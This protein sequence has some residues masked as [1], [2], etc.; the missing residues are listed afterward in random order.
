MMDGI[1]ISGWS[2]NCSL[3]ASMKFIVLIGLSFFGFQASA[4]LCAGV[5]SDDQGQIGHV[6]ESGSSKSDVR[7]ILG[8][9]RPIAEALK[10]LRAQ[11]NAPISSLSEFQKE[12]IL[13]LQEGAYTRQI[14]GALNRSGISFTVEYFE[15][16]DE[17]QPH[18]LG[19][20]QKVFVIQPTNE[21]PINRFARGLFAKHKIRLVYAPAI[22]MGHGFI[23][24]FSYTE[25]AYLLQADAIIEKNFADPLVTAHEIKHGLFL[26]ERLGEYSPKVK[27]PVQAYLKNT[28]RPSKTRSEY[29]EFLG[30]DEMVSYAYS[31]SGVANWISRKTVVSASLQ[32]NLNLAFRNL[33]EF[34]ERI[35]AESTEALEVLKKR[36]KT[37]KLDKKVE[38]IENG[39]QKEL[40]ITLDADRSLHYFLDPDLEKL[41]LKELEAR[42]VEELQKSIALA[43]FNLNYLSQ[44]PARSDSEMER[45]AYLG[46]FKSAQVEFL[47]SL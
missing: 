32:Q 44:R 3:L 26:L 34:S 1:S 5:L 37:K 9:S 16:R 22:A 7:V 17:E 35:E 19:L 46:L 47:E 2:Q 13:S 8:F 4:D 29:H 6:F 33:I 23:A 25:R 39:Q 24:A 28:S 43:Q 30:F 27:A 38:I 45:L 15:E 36:L 12:R 11:K 41:S 14:S 18:L 10:F 31:L 20:R 21:T 42:V 40:R